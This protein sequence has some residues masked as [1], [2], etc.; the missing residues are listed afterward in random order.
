MPN[1]RITIRATETINSFITFIVAAPDQDSAEAWADANASDVYGDYSPQ[2][3]GS[4]GWENHAVDPEATELTDAEP[5]Y[6]VEEEDE[7][8]SRGGTL[9]AMPDDDPPPEFL[10]HI[11]RRRSRPDLATS[12]QFS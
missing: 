9:M 11:L 5:D 1:Y 3:D 10:D 12:L 8:A 7:D 2:D 4:G 6:L